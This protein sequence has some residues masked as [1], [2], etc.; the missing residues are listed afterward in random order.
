MDRSR[1]GAPIA[2]G[3][4]TSSPADTPSRVASSRQQ[5]GGSGRW[6][7]N[8]IEEHLV[9]H[10]Y[11]IHPRAIRVRVEATA[12][13]P[14]GRGRSWTVEAGYWRI[15]ASTEK[16]AVEVLTARLHDFLTCYR[17]PVVLAFR[18][19]TAVV[20][21]DLGDSDHTVSFTQQIAGPDGRLHHSGHAA[22]GW[23]Q[24]ER[25]ARYNLAQMSTDWHDDASVQQAAAFLDRDR[26]TPGDPLGPDELYGYAAWQRAARAAMDAGRDDW[27]EWATT[28]RAEFDVPR[29]AGN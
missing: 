29:P 12:S 20:S 16:V 18:G 27:H 13:R 19:Y 2:P 11:T 6:P 22:D 3:R 17:P 15:E 10:D 7:S 1:E 25:Y 21:L 9:L 5:C 28:H 24:A 8:T 23:E 4:A 14:P 26:I